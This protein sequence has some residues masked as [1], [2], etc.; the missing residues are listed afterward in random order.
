[1]Q[2]VLVHHLPAVQPQQWDLGELTDEGTMVLTPS[3]ATSLPSSAHHSTPPESTP[4]ARGPAGKARA[5][6]RTVAAKARS[7]RATREYRAMAPL[8]N[9]G[10][11]F[12]GDPPIPL[13]RGGGTSL[14]CERAGAGDLPRQLLQVRQHLGHLRVQG[15]PALGHSS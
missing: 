9:G 5:P 8:T 7:G 1:M 13:S 14:G 15:H 2:Q 3:S 12:T 6:A 10:S 4:A 11:E